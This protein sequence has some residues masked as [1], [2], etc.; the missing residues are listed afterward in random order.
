MPCLFDDCA[1]GVYVNPTY[2]KQPDVIDGWYANGWTPS[3]GH[4]MVRD[5]STWYRLEKIRERYA[6]NLSAGFAY[7][8]MGFIQ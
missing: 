6:F 4:D 5:R 2:G 8:D 3:P 7:L 1:F